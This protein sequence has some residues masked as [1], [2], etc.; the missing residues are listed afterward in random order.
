MSK[1]YIFTAERPTRETAK[2]WGFEYTF[3]VNV[4][5]PEVGIVWL[6]KSQCEVI[7][8][9]PDNLAEYD[10]EVALYGPQD[11][12]VYVPGWLAYRNGYYDA[13]ANEAVWA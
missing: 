13:I 10:F 9:T 8:A 1:T 2:A 12:L 5:N 7:Q 11:V 6:P 4:I 3:G